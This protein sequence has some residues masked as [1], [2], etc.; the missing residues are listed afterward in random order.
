MAQF[1]LMMSKDKPNLPSLQVKLNACIF[2]SYRFVLLI[3][4][5][6]SGRI[7]VVKLQPAPSCKSYM[8]ACTEMP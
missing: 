7:P 2:L 5:W 3:L 8:G 1:S 4:I 6:A